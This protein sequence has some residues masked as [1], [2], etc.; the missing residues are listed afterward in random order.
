ML[1]IREAAIQAAMQGV[2]II[3]G[4]ERLLARPGEDELELPPRLTI[5]DRMGGFLR[6]MPAICYGI[7]Y[8]GVKTMNLHAQQGVRYMIQLIRIADGATVALMD[9]NWI[10]AYRTAAAAAIAAKH[11]KPAKAETI[12]VIGS[13]VQARALL[14][15]TLQVVPVKRVWISSPTAA[16]RERMA[17]DMAALFPDVEIAP[18]DDSAAAIGAADIVLSGYRAKNF[19]VI[20]A[21]DLKPGALVCGISSVRPQH[22]EVD[23]SIWADSRVVADDIE[24]VLESGDGRLAAEKGLVGPGRVIELW[25]VLR[26]P[27][28]GRRSAGETVLY[29]AVGTAEQDIALAAIVY[30]RVVALGLGEDLG[31]FPE[32]RPIQSERD[33][34]AIADAKVV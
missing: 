19:P 14:D 1:L 23:V 24:H 28:L 34:Q 8:S 3:G 31:D 17:A 4:L 2:D 13:G 16:N 12:T 5:N 33:K 29:K 6:M 30:D 7:G 32:C 25:E 26:N 21:K 11:L 15:S 22:R 18:A 20:F 10:T 9:A 27:A